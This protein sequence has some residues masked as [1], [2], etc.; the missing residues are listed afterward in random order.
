MNATLRGSSDSG[1]DRGATPPGDAA[2]RSPRAPTGDRCRRRAREP[3]RVLPLAARD[4]RCRSRRGD[5]RLDRQRLD[6]AS[7]LLS[8]RPGR[9]LPS[10]R[11]S[12][13]EEGPTSRPCRITRWPAGSSYFLW[14]SMP[15]AAAAGARRRP[16]DL[17]HAGRSSRGNPAHAARRPRARGLANEFGGNWLDF[18]RFEEHNT[19]DRER[20]PG[21]QQRAAPGH[22]RGADPF[23]RRSGPRGSLRAR[24]PLRRLHVRQSDPG[25]T[26]SDARRRQARR[27]SGCASTDAAPYERGGLLPMSVFLTQERARPAHQS[28]EARL[29]GC[30]PRARRSDPATAAGR[31]RTAH[32]RGEARNL[33]LRETLAQHRSDKSCAGCHARFDSFGL[34]AKATAP[35]ANGGQRSGGRP[36][37]YAGHVSRRQRRQRA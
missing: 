33:T 7:L 21:V 28:G 22:V 32:G 14:S 37:G 23:L 8:P 12:A 5:A 24:F 20:L 27:T 25:Q 6:V 10:R 36:G 2:A 3:A 26:L 16:E 18:R 30:A 31:S 34:A 9:L 1:V 11:D 19:V 4:G 29:L 35:L 15:D 17:H 13:K